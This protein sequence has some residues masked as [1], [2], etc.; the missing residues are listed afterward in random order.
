MSP[1]DM[2]SSL[3]PT[4][5]T[6]AQANPQSFQNNFFGHFKGFTLA[7]IANETNQGIPNQNFGIENEQ[8]LPNSN[9]VSSFKKSITPTTN[10]VKN[11]AATIN[12]RNT[13]QNSQLKKSGSMNSPPQSPQNVPLRT[14][15]P[16][17]T[18]PS[19]AIKIPSVHRANTLKPADDK[20]NVILNR[21]NTTATTKPKSIV[22]GMENVHS[23]SVAPALPPL[24]S[25]LQNS[26]PV[27][28]SPILEASTC[29]AKELISPLKQ[30]NP[31]SNNIPTR[32]APA[33]P[34]KDVP[35]SPPS[36]K[37][38][39]S[40]P[41]SVIN[42]VQSFEEATAKKPKEGHNT[43]NRIA[44]FLKQEKKDEEKTRN[45][46]E[47]SNSLPKNPNHQIKA[48]KNIDKGT[49]RNLPISNPIPQKDIELPT[50]TVPIVSDSE[51]GDDPKSVIMRAQS[52]RGT[53]TNPR[54]N[55]QT[56]GSMRQ[57]SG[58]KRPTSIPVGGRPKSPPPP[59]PEKVP[60]KPI[61]KPPS[62]FNF[63]KKIPGLPGYQ[64]T[65]GKNPE[66][67]DCV[68]E[69]HAPLANINEETTPD[70]IYAVIEESPPSSAS[71]LNLK[72]VN[73]SPKTITNIKSPPVSEYNSP[74]PVTN[75]H[76]TSSES[77]GL[78]G[79]IVSEIQNR[80]FDS[81]YS[82]ST[83][84][85]KKK[86]REECLKNGTIYCDE[87]TDFDN[88]YANTPHYK[89]PDNGEYNNTNRAKSVSSAASTT[90]SGYLNPSAVNVPVG[91]IP[92]DSGI[93]SI[94]SSKVNKFEGYKPYS[95]S[96]NRSLGPFASSYAKEK[97]ASKADKLTTPPS[98]T[99]KMNPKP[100]TVQPTSNLN[101][102]SNLPTSK[103]KSNNSPDVVS[104]C[105]AP[106]SNTIKSPDVVSSN[107]QV[108]K[109][110]G[111]SQG[112]VLRP[113]LPTSMSVKPL[114]QQ[115]P[116]ISTIPKVTVKQPSKPETKV[117]RS[118]PPPPDKKK[119]VPP[120]PTPPKINTTPPS[121]GL[122]SK[123][124]S[125]EKNLSS[126]GNNKKPPVKLNESSVNKTK[127]GV[128][129]QSNVANLQ[130]KFENPKATTVAKTSGAKKT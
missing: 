17:P 114:Q 19:V 34:S 44:S 47:R 7:P 56:F 46:V 23:A 57:P 127:I 64:N 5:Q 53:N 58:T 42:A 48:I 31:T 9:S 99:L 39:L 76:S 68:A 96:L 78:L 65:D 93:V 102:N 62:K 66:Y 18:I 28:S 61:V 12:S 116:P 82:T 101:G 20:Q 95:S 37:R 87:E 112:V 63:I 106:V 43:L 60:E 22:S 21:S 84:A 41:N 85:R 108:F 54:P 128:S 79:E 30:S 45:P 15:P 75:V 27:I 81:I 73:T 51:D 77:M 126:L 92:P 122:S 50:S 26:R 70:N 2:N 16:V 33:V 35:S 111:M 1:D 109:E 90:S 71:K 13:N 55:I 103:V 94:D 129:K 8:K 88:V 52:M 113:T 6:N 98:P 49:L 119:I 97:D 91:K 110:S 117:L 124:N 14:A 40:S 89:S 125:V 118:A 130:Q 69:T 83:L 32:A 38:P 36:N 11:V 123:S 104:S 25:N 80:N 59:R 121:S 24:N 107:G 4:S 72:N 100:P 67:D 120:R 74:K 29:T 3:L 115:K 105:A 86:Q 10:N